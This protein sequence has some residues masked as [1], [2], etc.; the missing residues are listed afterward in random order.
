[1]SDLFRDY[2]KKIGSGE[3]TSKN[4]TRTEAKTATELML[5]GT[6]TPAQIGGFM[7][8]HRIKRPTSTELAGM[9]DAYNQLGPQLSEI[10]HRSVVVLGTPYDGRSR[11]VPVTLIT[12]LLLAVN[13][14][15]VVLHGGD[16]MPTKYGIPLMSLFRE[17][18][19]DFSGLSLQ[20]I[21]RL[22]EDTG[23]GF[24]YIPQLFPQA[25]SLV[26]YRKQIGK[27]PP[28]ATLELIWSPYQ[29]KNGHLMVGFVHPPTESRC[30]ETFGFLNQQNYTFV[31]GLEG[32]CDLALSRP[33]I[34]G[35]GDQGKFSRLTLNPRDY[36]F[37]RHDIPLESLEQVLSLT[38][39]VLQGESSDLTAAA[40]WNG[41][42]YLWRLGQCES[43]EEGLETA[44]KTLNS[45]Y[46]M[47]K[48]T[49]VINYGKL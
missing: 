34:I 44:K 37:P 35:L 17:L 20:N 29:G 39:A 4:L 3:H 42:F 47:D 26:P 2:L 15:S 40:T 21:Q 5:Q 10:N 25:Q 33:G 24:I 43:L 46:L 23:L 9:I 7:I 11:T 28:F 30:I 1:M 48:L 8:A 16:Q 31:K 6:A 36:G 18:G 49:E 22:L 41:G 27:R 14:I 13:G 19:M 45:G 32:S 12:A 38:K